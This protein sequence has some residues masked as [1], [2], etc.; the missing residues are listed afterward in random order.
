MKLIVGNL[1]SEVTPGLIQSIFEAFGTVSTLSITKE[2]LTDEYV[3]QIEMPDISEAANAIEHVDG[4]EIGGRLV[5][6]KNKNELFD[7]ISR[8]AKN[9]ISEQ[10]ADKNSA[11]ANMDPALDIHEY[12]KMTTEN[13]RDLGSNRRKI[14]SPLFSR[15]K[16]IVIDRRNIAD[17]RESIPK[18]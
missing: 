10:V 1:S 2:N 13:R 8:A 5:I 4:K 9:E 11:K 7:E 3:A 17:R 16:G 14:K 15:E 18:D 6:I 12:E